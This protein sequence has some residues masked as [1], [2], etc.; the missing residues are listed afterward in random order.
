MSFTKYTYAQ[1]L[2]V[3]FLIFVI[4]TVQSRELKKKNR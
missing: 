3:I 1:A 4:Y 2:Y